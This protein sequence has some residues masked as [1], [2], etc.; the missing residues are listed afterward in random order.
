MQEIEFFEEGEPMI[1]GEPGDLKVKALDCLRCT[2][3]K[4]KV[5]TLSSLAVTKVTGCR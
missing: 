4:I 2:V 5:A 1:D 3:S